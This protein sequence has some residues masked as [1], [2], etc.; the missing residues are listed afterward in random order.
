LEGKSTDVDD[1]CAGS[2]SKAWR[3]E[4]LFKFSQIALLLSMFSAMIITNSSDKQSLCA[5][6]LGPRLTQSGDKLLDLF[7]ICVSDFE[8]VYAEP[9]EAAPSATLVKIFLGKCYSSS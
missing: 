2:D 7:S 1:F 4:I 8:I 6:D 5:W 3:N 9:G